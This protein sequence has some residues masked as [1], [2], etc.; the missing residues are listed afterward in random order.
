MVSATAASVGLDEPV[1][2]TVR[3]P[4]HVGI[5]FLLERDVDLGATAVGRGEVNR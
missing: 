1:A 3:C 5:P 4:Q 2:V